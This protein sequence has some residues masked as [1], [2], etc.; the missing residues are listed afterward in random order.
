M[1]YLRL[2]LLGVGA[3]NSPR[4]A[5]AGLLVRYRRHRVA[6]DAGPGADLPQRLDA[7]L[8][9]DEQAELHSA[10]KRMAADRGVEARTA[11]LELGGLVIHACPVAHTSH[12][13]CGYRIE[14]DGVAAVW[15]PEFW[16]FPSWASG[17]DLM[18]AEAA[19]WNRRIRFR[20]GLGGH[21]HVLEVGREAARYQVRRLVYAHIGRPCLRAMD[22]G[23]T[24][25]WGEW[26]REGRTYS[27][28]PE[29]RG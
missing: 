28:L 12:P 5:P 3:M 1:R 9:T 11:D 13:T 16:E 19:G 14:A 8:V 15:A 25:E 18:F 4:F 10:L 29:Q 7:W 22:A 20:G 17:A 24:P 2:T 26:G 27:L 23:L 6:F 21:A